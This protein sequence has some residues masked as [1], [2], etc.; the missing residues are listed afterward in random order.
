MKKFKI[1]SKFSSTRK[2]SRESLITW[3]DVNDRKKREVE[4]TAS[5]GLKYAKKKARKFQKLHFAIVKNY[6]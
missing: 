6:C 2:V 1:N 4:T 5:N 3:H